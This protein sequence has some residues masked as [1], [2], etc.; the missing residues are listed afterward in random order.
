MGEQVDTRQHS[1]VS[2]AV[3]VGA[4]AIALCIAVW[5]LLSPPDWAAISCILLAFPVAMLAY[6]LGRRA[7]WAS[8]SVG[9]LLA[10]A[11][12][13]P[14]LVV[15]GP[16]PG[17]V[18]GVLV[19]GLLFPFG[20]LIARLNERDRSAAGSAQRAPAEAAGPVGA[21]IGA[22]A[23]FQQALESILSD[24][25]QLVQ[26][27]A[28]ELTRWD[29]ERKCCVTQDWRGN[30][31]YTWEPGGTYGSLE[32]YAGWISQHR[33]PLLI[34]DIHTICLHSIGWSRAQ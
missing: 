33:R 14:G 8:A 12:T 31:A 7:A 30:R 24:A 25:H 17:T 29:E 11:S 9:A 5:I 26:Y 13:V 21:G 20:L 22:G 27:D 19:A 23:D 15:S 32:G 16:S 6:H 3:A 2:W 18:Q 1:R 10:I 28:I 34:G 4:V